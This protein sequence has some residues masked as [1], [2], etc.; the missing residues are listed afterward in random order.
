MGKGG[1]STH[2]RIHAHTH[3][4]TGKQILKNSLKILL[5]SSTGKRFEKKCLTKLFEF[6]TNNNVIKQ[7]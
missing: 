7:N 3:T 5:I 4:H 6:F 1:S 2:K